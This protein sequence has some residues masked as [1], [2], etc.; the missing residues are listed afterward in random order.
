MARGDCRAG[1]RRRWLRRLLPPLRISRPRRR[2]CDGS[3]RYEYTT[4]LG[5]AG[6]FPFGARGTRAWPPGDGW[7]GVFSAEQC[8]FPISRLLSWI[9]PSFLRF[10]IKFPDIAARGS[11]RDEA[12][13]SLLTTRRARDLARRARLGCEVVDGRGDIS[14]VSE[15][16]GMA[17]FGRFRRG[18]PPGKCLNRRIRP[19]MTF[20]N[21]AAAEYPTCAGPAPW[22]GSWRLVA[23]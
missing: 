9:Q 8:Q 16:L 10:P 2:L 19:L 12:V 3:R 13:Q 20:S 7:F 21:P 1:R 11:C 4:G 14:W 5:G 18:Q 23:P 17:S 6:W 22:G 15:L